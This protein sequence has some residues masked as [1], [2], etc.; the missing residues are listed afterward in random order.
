MYI[1]QKRAIFTNTRIGSSS[2]Q[3]VSTKNERKTNRND[4]SK[5]FPLSAWSEINFDAYTRNS[6]NVE[7][8]TLRVVAF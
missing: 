4:R 3:K 6:N 7:N 8:I 1:K 5:T 2:N